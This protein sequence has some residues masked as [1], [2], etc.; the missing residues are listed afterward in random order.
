MRKFIVT[1]PRREK[2]SALQ[3]KPLGNRLLDWKQPFGM[4]VRVLFFGPLKDLLGSSCDE[5]DLPPGTDYALFSNIIR[6]ASRAFGSWPET[7]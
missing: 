3:P 6:P 5:T 7:S 4:R 1:P 2:A